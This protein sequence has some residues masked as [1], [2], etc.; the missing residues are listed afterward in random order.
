[1]TNRYGDPQV[2]AWMKEHEEE[3]GRVMRLYDL[4]RERSPEELVELALGVGIDVSK[5][6]A[7]YRDTLITDIVKAA[8]ASAL[9]LLEGQAILIPAAGDK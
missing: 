1:M 5:R 3:A 4:L 8:P 2:R 7:Q 9:K 6:R